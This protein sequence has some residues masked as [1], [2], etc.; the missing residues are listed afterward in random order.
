VHSYPS[1]I[2]AILLPQNPSPDHQASKHSKYSKTSEV[3]LFLQTST[4]H[5]LST[6]QSQTQTQNLSKSKTLK[7]TKTSRYLK[8][9]NKTKTL[10]KAITTVRELIQKRRNQYVKDERAK[11]GKEIKLITDIQAQLEKKR[12][13]KEIANIELA[14]ELKNVNIPLQFNMATPDSSFYMKELN[15]KDRATVNVYYPQYFPKERHVERPKGILVTNDERFRR[16]T[17]F[18]LIFLCFFV[19]FFSEIEV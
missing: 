13:Q 2:P 4:T 17:F 15:Q 1:N 19:I 14:E 10:D 5:D 3:P 11:K 16:C 18:F 8:P 12:A 9:I 7:N 6:T